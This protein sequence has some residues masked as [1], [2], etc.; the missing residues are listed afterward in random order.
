[1]IKKVYQ[2][3]PLICPRCGFRMRVLW[4]IED[5]PVVRRILDHLGLWD[6]PKRAPPVHYT[7]TESIGDVL[8][9]GG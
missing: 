8:P 3:D 2:V 7:A 5:P 1:M 4:C 6:T 9:Q